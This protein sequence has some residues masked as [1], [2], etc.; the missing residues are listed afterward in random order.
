MASHITEIGEHLL[1]VASI[2]GFKA[3]LRSGVEDARGAT[4]VEFA[5]VSL[6]LFAIL[7]CALQTS[8]IFFFEQTLQTATSQ[9]ARQIMVGAPQSSGLSQSKFQSAVCGNLPSPFS[10]SSVMVDVQ[11]A[12]D[13]ASLNTNPITITYNG[14]GTVSNNFSYSPGGPGDIVIIRV[15]YNWPVFA[16]PM[17]FFLSNQP[18]GNHLMVGTAVIKNEPFS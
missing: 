5:L 9:A 7:I 4:A 17:G 10:C 14:N 3:K 15:Y 1:R 16:D 11:S 6:P 2:K 12:K 18:G 13:Y 8:I